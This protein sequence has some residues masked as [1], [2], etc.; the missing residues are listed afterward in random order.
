MSLPHVS[1]EDRRALCE[2]PCTLDGKPAKI[3][4]AANAYAEVHQ[5]PDGFG[6]HWSWP[7]VAHIL[8]NGG[9]FR[10]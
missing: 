7:A 9:N 1:I 6:W 2:M 10:S 8:A 4:G 3:I 5:T